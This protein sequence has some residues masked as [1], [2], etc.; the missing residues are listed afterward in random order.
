VEEV[1]QDLPGADFPQVE[2]GRQ[3]PLG[4]SDLLLEDGAAGS[5]QTVA[6]TLVVAASFGQRLGAV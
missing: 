1:G 5:G 2:D 3:Y 6:A 4:V